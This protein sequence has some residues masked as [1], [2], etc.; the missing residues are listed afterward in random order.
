MIPRL[1]GREPGCRATAHASGIAIANHDLRMKHVYFDASGIIGVEKP[2]G[3]LNLIATRIRQI[4]LERVLYG[5]GRSPA[6]VVTPKGHG[7]HSASAAHRGGVQDHREQPR[8][9][10]AFLNYLTVPR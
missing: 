1:C 7:R 3:R 10:R 9:V 4:G 5:F 6:T 8:A 2:S